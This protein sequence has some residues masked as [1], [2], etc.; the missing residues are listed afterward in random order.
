MLSA[1][2][3]IRN[4]KGIPQQSPESRLSRALRVARWS[5]DGN[6]ERVSQ[7]AYGARYRTLGSA[8]FSFDFE[9]Q[10]SLSLRRAFFR[11]RSSDQGEG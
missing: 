4:P 3:I 2:G 6:P 9:K 1:T 11:K 8:L 10:F 7:I 5:Y